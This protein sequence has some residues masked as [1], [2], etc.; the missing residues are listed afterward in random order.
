[1]AFPIFQTLSLWS[2]MVCGRRR[3]PKISTTAELRS[4]YH[5]S[6]ISLILKPTVDKTLRFYS[7]ATHVVFFKVS[8]RL[9]KSQNRSL[10]PQQ[11]DVCSQL[12][13]VFFISKRLLLPYLKAT[14][15]YLSVWA[16][17]EIQI[18]R[19]ARKH[20]QWA[21]CEICEF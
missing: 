14:L 5:Q 3:D 2:V 4:M 1:M 18:Y 7:S 12:R 17:T 9:Q 19:N 11:Q 16:S 15:M 13:S 20:N 21:Y 8:L 6:G 10:Q